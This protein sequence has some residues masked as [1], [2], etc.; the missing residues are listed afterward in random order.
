MN[1]P[2]KIRGNEEQIIP[3]RACFHD[4]SELKNMAKLYINI[5]AIPPKKKKVAN[6]V[7]IKASVFIS[8]K[9]TPKIPIRVKILK[10]KAKNTK[11]FNFWSLVIKKLAKY[12]MNGIDNAV[13]VSIP[14]ENTILEPFGDN[15][16][17]V[18]T[19]PKSLIQ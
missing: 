17:L 8:I 18:V 12:I 6:I 1:E 9:E 15:P 2:K 4:T 14:I 3:N 7:W 16:V 10:R 11:N 19:P 13:N 5:I